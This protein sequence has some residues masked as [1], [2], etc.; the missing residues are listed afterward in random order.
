MVP[1]P[2]NVPIANGAP[3]H[4]DITGIL[5]SETAVSDDNLTR[6]LQNP[7]GV[8]FDA[9]YDLRYNDNAPL[10]PSSPSHSQNR[11]AG[12]TDDL[13]H[14]TGKP[15]ITLSNSH[16]PPHRDQTALPPNGQTTNRLLNTT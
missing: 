1:P 5:Q 8:V 9:T 16:R 7:R 11:S 2:T 14:L 12:R 6:T 3:P 4:I 10:N 13:S 15:A